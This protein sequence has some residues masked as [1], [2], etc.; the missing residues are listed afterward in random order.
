MSA[1]QGQPAEVEEMIDGEGMK[2]E[3]GNESIGEE[4]QKVRK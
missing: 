1:L 3:E 4:E 2:K